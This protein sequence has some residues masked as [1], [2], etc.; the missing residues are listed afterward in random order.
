MNLYYLIA[1]VNKII[2]FLKNNCISY[3]VHLVISS[4]F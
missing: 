1:V 3:C 2:V 4:N